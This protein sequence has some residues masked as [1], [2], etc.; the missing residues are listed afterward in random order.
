[1]VYS[2]ATSLNDGASV[3]EGSETLLAADGSGKAAS[4]ATRVLKLLF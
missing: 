4:E 1:M 3:K 2:E